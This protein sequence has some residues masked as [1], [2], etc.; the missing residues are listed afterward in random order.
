MPQNSP[1]SLSRQQVADVMA[2]IFSRNGFPTGDK[3]L[4]K[5]PAYMTDIAFRPSA[6]H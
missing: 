2:Y 5:R 1:G 6:D 4:P 3:D